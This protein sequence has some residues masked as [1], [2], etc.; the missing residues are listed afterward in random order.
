[1]GEKQNEQE[2]TAFIWDV[3]NAS[4]EITRDC[5]REELE[6]YLIVPILAG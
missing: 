2:M 3:N 5:K 4:V 6:L 1:M